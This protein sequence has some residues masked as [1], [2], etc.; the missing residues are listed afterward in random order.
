MQAHN[1]YTLS[2]SRLRKVLGGTRTLPTEKQIVDKIMMIKPPPIL[3]CVDSCEM[4]CAD[5]A[6][7]DPCNHNEMSLLVSAINQYQGLTAANSAVKEDIC[8]VEWLFFVSI[9]CKFVS[10][11]F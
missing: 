4:K 7:S 9:S 3:V 6:G 2:H 8:F 5:Y 11:I 10:A 1:V